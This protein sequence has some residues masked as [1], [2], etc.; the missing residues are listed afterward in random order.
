[1]KKKIE[2]EFLLCGDRLLRMPRMREEHQGHHRRGPGKG[3]PVQ[4]PA[5][6]QRTRHRRRSVLKPA[7]V[8]R[9]LRGK[10]VAHIPA[11]WPVHTTVMEVRIWQGKGKK[12]NGRQTNTPAPIR[13]PILRTSSTGLWADRPARRLRAGTPTTC[14]R[15]AHKPWAGVCVR[16]TEGTLIP[17]RHPKFFL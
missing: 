8:C 2:F 9:R 11:P 5:L 12:R 17:R 15:P 14:E 7:R 10:G 4:V 1:M 13:P 3:A 16:Q 6:R